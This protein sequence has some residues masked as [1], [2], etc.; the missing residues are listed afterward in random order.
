L[1]KDATAAAK[2]WERTL[3]FF[4]QHLGAAQPA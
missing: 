1:K 3:E 4:E 2:A